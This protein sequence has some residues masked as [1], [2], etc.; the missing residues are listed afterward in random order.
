MTYKFKRDRFR[1]ARGGTSRLLA[2]S[3]EKCDRLI[4]YYQKDGPGVL[5]RL[6]IDRMIDHTNLADQLICGGCEQVVGIRFVYTKED[7]PAYR[8]FTGAVTKKIVPLATLSDE[9]TN[10]TAGNGSIIAG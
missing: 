10:S 8:L 3:C 2:V 6:Y 4:S 1:A 9:P 7:R 5:K